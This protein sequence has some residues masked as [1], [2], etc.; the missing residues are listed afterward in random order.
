[1]A[2]P[3]RTMLKSHQSP[4]AD[5]P[6]QKLSFIGELTPTEQDADGDGIT[7]CDH[8]AEPATFGVL[9]ADHYL[10]DR[11]AFFSRRYTVAE[12]G[13]WIW[14]GTKNSGGYGLILFGES[15]L[16]AHRFSW[17]IANNRPISDGL[18]ICH[19]C[20]TPACVNPE[21]LW[22]G[23]PKQNA[24]DSMAKGRKAKVLTPEKVRRIYSLKRIGVWSDKDIAR[25]AGVSPSTVSLLLRGRRWD[26]G[27]GNRPE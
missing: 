12:S 20:D 2:D 15:Q 27:A 26:L 3:Y 8:C 23:T 9:C 10:A 11:R 1:M 14:S 21:H 4:V 13:C 22:E 18:F 24:V 7:P 16:A 19:S 6:V 5:Y 25:I 17:A